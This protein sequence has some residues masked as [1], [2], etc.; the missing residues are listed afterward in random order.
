MA[1]VSAAR[2]CMDSGDLEAAE[3]LLGEA[4]R[5]PD[6]RADGHVNHVYAQV[7][8]DLGK[9]DR[10][11]THYRRAARISPNNAELHRDLGVAYEMK[12]W[13]KEAEACFRDAIRLE[14]QDDLAQSYLG[15]TLR[16]Q[17]DNRSALRH[18][19]RAAWL[20]VCRRLH[21]LPRRAAANAETP[22]LPQDTD[23]V[24]AE[25]AFKAKRYAEAEA[26]LMP[27]IKANA[28][29]AA[30]F[31]LYAKICGKTSRLEEGIRYARHATALS[32]STADVHVT[33][34][35]LLF[36]ADLLDE[37]VASLEAA[38]RA[39]PEH[40]RAHGHFAL[41]EQR[42]EHNAEAE[43]LAK[44]ALELD[45]ESS[46]A[47]NVMGYVL[48]SQGRFEEAEPYCRKA[49]A[50]D[51][52]APT[53]YLSLAK[54]V[55]ERGRLDEARLLVQQGA[56]RL[57]DEAT[58]Y[59]HLA[60]FEFDMGDLEA[61]IEHTRRALTLEPRHLDGHM[62]LANLLLLTGRYEE[63]WQEYEWRKRYHKQVQL[64]DIFR[65]RLEGFRQWAGTT[66]EGKT[67]LV[68]CEQALG[69]QILFA[70]CLEQVATRAKA[71]TVLCDQRLHGL[72]LRSLPGVRLLPVP[73]V[74]KINNYQPDRDYDF[75]C[76]LGSLPGLLRLNAGTIPVQRG[77]LRPDETKVQRWHERLRALGPGPKI[78]ISWRGGMI[79]T[80]RFKRSLDLRALEPIL[81][82][83]GVHWVNLQYTNVTREIDELRART[84]IN[85]SHWQEG[86]DDFDEHA[87]LAAALDHRVSVC[88][89][90]VHL[91]GAMG[92]PTW[93]LSPPATIWPYGLGDRM[94][95]YPSVTIYR[96]QRYKD[97]SGPI[98]N[99]ARDL[100]TLV[101]QRE[102]R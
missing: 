89:T 101:Q 63:G 62:T 100:R 30:A 49:I 6:G 72:L 13:P 87:A 97:W 77:Y 85:I 61:A 41:I 7:L 39:D 98:E 60:N 90:L 5:S 1:V 40:A 2:K 65:A 69:E 31:A 71:V 64:H 12:G 81:A 36:G 38:L 92:L 50:L 3:K 43:R 58:S 45:P 59:C 15:R 88:N 27:V 75:W 24:A 83:P 73:G 86:I 80:G 32:G 44:R 54:S 34:A 11:I 99:L 9:L 20:K 70:Q 23:V 29:S 17:G 10:A 74:D 4:A 25:Q 46:H 16:A 26:K 76:A 93:I 102:A 78:G 22:A 94:P 55:K 52:Q 57:S 8:H 19:G 42:R 91:S 79:A 96:Q 35:E 14:P 48:L 53:P 21:I 51:P 67:L 68:H 82:T 66:L 33:L 84:G 37:A 18:F 56:E 28:N 95:W 47:N